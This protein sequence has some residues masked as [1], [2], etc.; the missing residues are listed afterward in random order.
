M[1]YSI[2]ICF[3]NKINTLKSAATPSYL[4]RQSIKGAQRETAPGF[5]WIKIHCWTQ[6][7]QFRKTAIRF[8]NS[9]M[10]NERTFKQKAISFNIDCSTRAR[11]RKFRSR[12]QYNL[13]FFFCILKT[14]VFHICTVINSSERFWSIII[15]ACFIFM[16]SFKSVLVRLIEMI[17]AHVFGVILIEIYVC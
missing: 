8:H 5:N 3:H 6:P 2:T 14:F 13:L 7:L 10:M 1:V 11:I 15:G 16:S 17:Y 12:F 4:D 9:R